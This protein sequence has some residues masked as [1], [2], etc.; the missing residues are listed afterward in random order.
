MVTN[1]CVE[2]SRVTMESVSLAGKTVVVTGANTGIG[3]ETARELAKR[4]E[5]LYIRV[6]G[7]LHDPANVQQ[8]SSKCI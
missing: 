6:M 5:L 1:V 2:F 7:C 4:G 8:T 3:K